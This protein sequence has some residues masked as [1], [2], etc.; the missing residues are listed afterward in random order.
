[1]T[2]YSYVAKDGPGDAVKGE[3]EADSREEA[4]KRLAQMGF[5]PVSLNAL[6]SPLG[7]SGFFSGKKIREKDIVFITRQFASLL[8]AGISVMNALG[9]V[10][11]QTSNLYLKNVLAGVMSQIKDGKSLSESFSAYPFAFS[12]LYC[13]T[14]K[15]GEAGGYL[16]DSMNRLADYLEKTQNYKSSILDSLAYPLFV[17]T[18]GILTVFVLLLFVIPRIVQMFQDMGQALPLPTRI[19]IGLSAGM[20]E[21]GWIAAGGICLIVFMFFRLIK[22]VRGKAAWDLFVI[23]LP[24]IGKVILKTEIGRFMRMVSMLLTGGMPIV[25]SLETAV[26]TMENEVLKKEIAGFKQEIINGSSFSDTLS[27]SKFFPEFVA[28]IVSVGEET[29]SL[30]VSLMRVS[31]SYEKEVDQVLKAATRL[32]EPVIILAVGLFVGFIVL[33]MLLPIFEINFIVR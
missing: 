18:T 32:I 10:S 28:S 17:L 20:R 30:D 31:D 15:T 6:E 13:S 5:F 22:S 8:D 1:M 2:K 9:S 25:L 33:S 19:L 7:Q 3:I 4:V 12:N 29:G 23:R 26:T 24:L 21:Y 14:V 11:K 16:K 27:R